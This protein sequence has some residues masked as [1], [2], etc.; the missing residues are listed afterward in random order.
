MKFHQHS[1]AE[2]TRLVESCVEADDGEN[3]N[4]RGKQAEWE[5]NLSR[6][7]K[8][9]RRRLKAM[10]LQDINSERTEPRHKRNFA[11]YFSVLLCCGR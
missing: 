2:F 1:V 4:T 10:I 3:A 11:F 7:E 8:G 6:H 5:N 9:R